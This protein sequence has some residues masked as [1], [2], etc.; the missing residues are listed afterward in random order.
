MFSQLFL[1]TYE[2]WLYRYVGGI[3][4]S[5]SA[6]ENVSITPALTESIESASAWT[7]TPFGN[8]TV[9][10]KNSTGSF[11]LDVGIP[12]GVNATL[13]LPGSAGLNITEGGED[14][15]TAQGVNLL[16]VDGDSVLINVGSGNYHF[17]AV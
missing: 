16:G 3:K 5:S 17:V 9:D 15:A 4:L 8:L 12:V 7:M 14:V 1:G 10:W 6:F 11:T 13:T 2:D